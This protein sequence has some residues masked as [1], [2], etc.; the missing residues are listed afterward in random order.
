TYPRAAHLGPRTIPDREFA[1]IIEGEA[2]ITYDAVDWLMRPGDLLLIAP[3]IVHEFAWNP[4]GPTR[5]GYI[6]FSVAEPAPQIRFDRPVLRGPD[7]SRL[8]MLLGHLL[9]VAQ[10]AS[11]GEAA[12]VDLLHHGLSFVLHSFAVAIQRELLA[13]ATHRPSHPAI[14]RAARRIESQW[15]GGAAPKVTVAALAHYARVSEAHLNRLVKA[16]FGHRVSALLRHMRLNHA[17]ELLDR[18]DLSVKAIADAAGYDN[19]F[20]FSRAFKTAFGA[21]PGELRTALRAGAPR[22]LPLPEL[23]RDPG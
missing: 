15:K 12:A 8:C 11:A 4:Q 6:H 14:Q 20:A 16:R 22:P 5:H 3:G 1:W 23:K 18:T 13:P 21:A 9:A 10:R 7:A 2:T 19:R 17:V